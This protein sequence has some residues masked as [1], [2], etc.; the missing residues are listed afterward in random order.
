MPDLNR[1]LSAKAPL[2]LSAIV[3][4]A[5]PLVLADLARAAKG[6]A[7]FI[8]PDDA[9]MRAIADAAQFFAPELEV[10]EFPAWDCL[11]YDR[12]SPALSVSAKRLAAL[13]RL[14]TVQN[15]PQLFVTTANAV[16]QRVL[17]PFRIRESVRMLKPGTEIARETLI[18]LL[19]R[20]GYSRTDTVADAGEFAVRGSIFDIYPSGL[21]QGLRLDFFGDELESLRLFD[22]NTQRSTGTLEGHLLLPASEALIDDDTVKR[23]RSRYRE[24]FGA[25]ATS[26]PLYQAVSDG[27]RLAGMEHWLPLFEERLVT[28]FDHFDANDLVLVESGATSAADERFKDIADYFATRSETSGTSAGS[29]RPLEPASLYLTHEEW[30]GHLAE[31]PVHRTDA[32][33]R[34]ESDKVID[35]G[36]SNARDFAPERARGDN[37]YEAAA[38]HLHGVAK[39][40][41][42]ALIAAY[43]KGSRARIS[44]ILGEAAAPEPKLA[45]NWQEALG[46][47]AKGVPVAL[48][49]PLESGFANDDLEIVTEQDIL[50]DRLVRRKKRRKDAD[51][52]LAEL[53]ALTPGDLVV[54]MD[55]GIGRYEGLQSIPVGKSPH[56]CVMLTYAGGDKLYIPVENL[57]VLS[58]YGSA[59]ETVPLDRLGGEAWQKRKSRLKERIREIAHELLKT[60]AQRALRQ[61][62]TFSPEGSAFDQFVD[63]FPWEETDDQEAAIGDV[64]EDLSSG[65]PMDRLVCGDVGFGKTA[66]AMRAAF[67]A[68]MSGVQVA[69]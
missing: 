7:V 20:Q 32:F 8:A 63:R 12:S 10:V 18:G 67:V 39:K 64:L 26:D 34:P 38:K 29:Y 45:D 4:G 15:G 47:A 41:R 5:Q 49:L 16:T 44:S 58:R 53:A 60:A 42:K 24:K 65:K 37:A 54:H 43:S 48:V 31:W 36:F 35:F 30:D 23:F 21:D 46:L 2:T 56:D 27:R 69:V 51:A 68:A 3:R 66:V 50:G 28:L 13:H 9:A 62:P 11:P 33:A 6:R 61:A 52:F 14:Q 59:E 40:G 19:Q 25:N 17:T 1:I 55:H 22:P 57:E